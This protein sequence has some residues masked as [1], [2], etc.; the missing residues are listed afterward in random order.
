MLHIKFHGYR[1]AG[2]RD[3]DFEGFAIYGHGGHLGNVTS[4]GGS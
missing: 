4:R 2:S 3:E 1:P